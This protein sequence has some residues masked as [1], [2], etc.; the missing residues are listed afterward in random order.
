MKWQCL[1]C[2]SWRLTAQNQWSVC[3][4]AYVIF[5]LLLRNIITASLRRQIS[6]TSRF[7]KASFCFIFDGQ[8]FQKTCNLKDFHYWVID[9][10]EN[11]APLSFI[12]F[13]AAS[14][15]RR[16]ALDTYFS[17]EK[18]SISLEIGSRED[19]NSASRIGAVVVSKRPQS[20]KPMCPHLPF[21]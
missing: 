7:G 12:F 2:R 3:L 9:I 20:T 16:P 6:L 8:N 4:T 11:H 18:S 13:W 10:T 21:Y 17:S 5:H 19:V 15:T 14:K 1:P